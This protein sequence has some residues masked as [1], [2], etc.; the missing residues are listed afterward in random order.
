MPF[1]FP[2]M[3]CVQ[4]GTPG[5]VF[6]FDAMSGESYLFLRELVGGAQSSVNLVANII[7][8]EVV[9]QKVDKEKLRLAQ[10]NNLTN[11]PEDR[12]M[13][14][15]AC[16]DALIHNPTYAIPPQLTPRWATCISHET[17][18]LVVSAGFETPRPV[19]MRVSYW[20]LCNGGML[21]DWLCT[22][23]G[24]HIAERT[25]FPVSL[26][27]RCISQI[28]E[29]LHIMYHAGREP[30]Y[31]CDLHMANVF[32]H[33][34]PD[35]T[36]SLPD[37][38]IGDF[39]WARTASEAQ[40]DT[41]FLFD[42]AACNNIRS[43]WDKAHPGFQIPKAHPETGPPGQRRRWDIARFRDSLKHYITDSITS[44]WELGAALERLMNVM[45]YLDN[46]DK[47][48]AALNSDSRPPS[49]LELVR[50]ARKLEREALAVEQKD[51]LFHGIL[52]MR[53]TQAK[54][55]MEDREP[56]VFTNGPN[57]LASLSPEQARSRAE[58]YGKFNI[59]GP[60]TLLE[61][62]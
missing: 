40:Q 61:S 33:I 29:T 60:W 5:Y 45:L 2:R 9:V 54:M 19:A 12:E 37:F 20:K 51:K 27:A 6:N 30:I 8:G 10:A 26:M 7:T 38:Y 31:H 42:R 46:K 49:L 56:F 3:G 39:G 11:V 36:T 4:T 22:W 50:E 34:D 16:L 59:E 55:F 58:Q 43:A 57:G 21:G 44:G 41:Q 15:H 18:P 28:S 35:S 25:R 48:L 23:R 52:G 47:E 14:I 32:V 17:V 13:H 24:N 53:R 62:V 1:N